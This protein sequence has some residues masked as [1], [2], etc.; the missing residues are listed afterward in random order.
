MAR[1]SHTRRAIR[2]AALVPQG[3]LWASYAGRSGRKGLTQINVG[4]MT[5]SGLRVQP[6]CWR[7]AEQSGEGSGRGAGVEGA[8][9]LWRTSSRP[10]SPSMRATLSRTSWCARDIIAHGHRPP[11]ADPHLLHHRSRAGA[12]SRSRQATAASLRCS[13]NARARPIPASDPVTNATRTLQPG[14]AAAGT[15]DARW[16]SHRLVH[17]GYW[18]QPPLCGAGAARLVR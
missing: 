10:H 6:G 7:S 14:G 9:C 1:R 18:L 2:P 11:P 12:S 15:G 3:P 17:L 8:G 16:V 13:R 5:K 4:G